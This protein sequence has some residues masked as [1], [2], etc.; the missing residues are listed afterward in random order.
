MSLTERTRGADYCPECGEAV[1]WIRLMSGQ[2]I[3][4]QPEPVLYIPHAGRRWLVEGKRWDAD[5]L[6]DCDIWEPGKVK[7][8]LK[9]GFLPHK[10]TECGK[11]G[12]SQCYT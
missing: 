8:N 2:W 5:I 10:F 9:K 4:V 3:A 6:K 11:E 7:D 1:K 12:G